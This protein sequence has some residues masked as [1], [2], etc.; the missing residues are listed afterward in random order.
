VLIKCPE[1]KREISSSAVSCPSCGYPISK[2]TKECTDC[3]A[4]IPIDADFCPE[5]SVIQLSKKTKTENIKKEE[6]ASKY[7]TDKKKPWYK[8]WWAISAFILFGL[9]I[10]INLLPSDKPPVSELE[11]RQQRFARMS[12]SE[13][14]NEAKQKFN[15]INLDKDALSVLQEKIYVSKRHLKAIE[16][17][18]P[19]N[20]EAQELLKKIAVVEEEVR[21]RAIEAKKKEISF[22]L[23]EAKKAL[24]EAQF[25]KD[26]MKT[27]YGRVSDA[28]KHLEAIQ[29]G[30]PEYP[31]AQKLIKEVERRERE[32]EKTSKIVALQIATK[33]REAFAQQY[34]KELLSKGMDVEV[35]VR[36]KYNTTIHLKY[37]L[38][39]RPLIY[40]LTNETSFF[41]NLRQR[42]FGKVVFDDGYRYTWTYNLNK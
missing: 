30:T 16:K 17:G 40:K 42:G 38:F 32:I 19:E 36:G 5:C 13:H 20:L 12:P 9:L 28:R 27:S 39:S 21:K 25:N 37:V 22:H 29:A 6:F 4:K 14:L 10:V 23:S 34:E 8:K 1:C 26:P 41:E 33:Q 2:A 11:K 7:I 35:S 31:E 18:K 24:A 3:G 15:E